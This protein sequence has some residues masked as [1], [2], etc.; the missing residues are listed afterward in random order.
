MI[1]WTGLRP[2]FVYRVS[3]RTPAIDTQLAGYD[4]FLLYCLIYANRFTR[5]FLNTSAIAAIFATNS[6][7][8]V[9]S[10]E[11]IYPKKRLCAL[12]QF[13]KV[14][15]VQMQVLLFF[16]SDANEYAAVSN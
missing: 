15:R 8:S 10:S 1:V 6:G 13:F 16:I 5:N 12:H 4:I 3:M 9:D 7:N 14:C 2:Q 11:L